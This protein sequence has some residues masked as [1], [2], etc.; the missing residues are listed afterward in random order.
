M[1]TQLILTTLALGVAACGAEEPGRVETTGDAVD[2]VVTEPVRAP[3][4]A[5]HAAEVGSDRSVDIATRMS[6]TVR[7][8]HVDIGSVVRAGD[9]LISLDDEDIVAR[10]EAA[11]AQYALA[12]KEH[13]RI[14]RL[15]ANGAAS[16]QELDR[17]A[18]ALEGARSALAEA[19]AQKSYAVVRAPFEG[20][21]TARRIDAGD[22]AN[23]GVPLLSLIDPARIE[24][25]AD[26]PAYLM[27]TLSEGSAVEVQVDGVADPAAATVT[28][29]GPT[30]GEG[31]RTFR[32]EVAPTEPLEGAYPGAYARLSV[33]V[34]GSPSR[35]I[36]ADAVVERGQLRG[37]F[38]VEDDVIRLRWVRLGLRRADAVELLSG[39]GGAPSIVRRPDVSLRDGLPVGSVREEGW[40]PRVATEGDDR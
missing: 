12:E 39:P 22:L 27:G 3:S 19:E 21:V 15:H 26:L 32:V 35:W 7:E 4:V 37:I 30:V 40:S 34:D 11:Q 14:E 29:V 18:A 33:P 9:R 23:P 2:V 16:T 6:G 5:S 24:V 38:V 10:I 20:V 36:P 28:R 13:G 1:K 25:V 8:V 31:A 17:S